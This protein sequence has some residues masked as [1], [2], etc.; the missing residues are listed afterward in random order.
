[1]ARGAHSRHSHTPK[2]KNPHQHAIEVDV[3]SQT[4][5]AFDGPSLVHTFD[6]ITGDK[7]HPT[8]K[9][10][11]LIFLKDEK[12]YSSKYHV[13][14][15]YAMFFTHDGKAIHQ[16]HGP[17]FWLVRQLKQDASDWFGSHGCVRLTE[18]D[19][20]TLYEWAPVNTRVIVK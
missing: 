15:Y 16:Y 10:N 6:C 4:L 2:P 17:A 12:H 8:D 11:F 20:K 19:A 1:M 3:A 9:G 14:M 13:K 18:E 7:D 5:K